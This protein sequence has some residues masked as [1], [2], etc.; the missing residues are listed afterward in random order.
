[1][2]SVAIHVNWDRYGFDRW[3]TRDLDFGGQSGVEIWALRIVLVVPPLPACLAESCRTVSNH[4]FGT[5][6]RPTILDLVC[7]IAAWAASAIPIIA[8]I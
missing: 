3:I 5:K 6:A 8:S 7:V 4:V 2:N 1:M